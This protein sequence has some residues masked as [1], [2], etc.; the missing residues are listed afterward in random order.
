MAA[1]RNSKLDPT[2]DCCPTPRNP[3]PQMEWI[4][5]SRSQVDGTR[6]TGKTVE[7]PTC[8]NNIPGASPITLASLSIFYGKHVTRVK[9]QLL[10]CRGH[11]S[12]SVKIAISCTRAPPQ[13]LTRFLPFATPCLPRA[14]LPVVSALSHVRI[15][16][17]EM[18][19]L[20]RH[21]AE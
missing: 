12:T 15:S 7:R 13:S 9:F 14:S 2:A 8:L 3:K 5:P 18:V 17:F 10:T 1:L 21:D 16:C 4:L 6:Q 19:C 11:L 20:S